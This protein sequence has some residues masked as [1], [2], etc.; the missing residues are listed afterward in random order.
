MA[1]TPEPTAPILEY[2]A[3]PLC[4]GN[5]SNSLYAFP[6]FYVVR[7]KACGLFYLNPRLNESNILD[8][9]ARELYD[10]YSAGL[11]YEIQ[12]PTL[13]MTFRRFLQNLHKRKLTGGRLLEIGCGSGF[14]I[15]EAKSYFSYRV[16]TDMSPEAAKKAKTLADEV[17]CGDLSAVPKSVPLFDCVIA[18]SVIE[19]I[20]RP[21]AF[22]QE[23]LERLSPHGKLV[24][25]TPN[26]D[27]LY[28][29]I[30]RKKWPFFIPP[31]HV[32]LYSPKTLSTLLE[33][34]HL[35]DVDCFEPAHAWPLAAFIAKAKLKSLARKMARTSL[36]KIPIFMPKTIVCVVGKKN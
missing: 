16:A 21:H 30:L 25:A 7:C 27:T 19:H 15:D 13:R 32:C 10:E 20:Y 12:E 26:I 6:P 31:E 34:N 22:I 14:L 35:H 8:Y 36:G 4:N 11:G 29:K 33:Q 23:I 5:E 17:Y 24:L 18:F 2:T 1:P 9:Y 28:Y 3:C